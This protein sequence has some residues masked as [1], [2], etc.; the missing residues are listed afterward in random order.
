MDRPARASLMP[1][2]ALLAGSL[3]PSPSH[4]AS[5]PV[6]TDHLTSRLVA[7]TT[8][9]VPGEPLT[10]GLLRLAKGLLLALEYQ[11]GAREGRLRDRP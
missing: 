5:D 7:E 4:G 8:A 1:L 11:R 9:A 10:V 3:A 6:R 2:L